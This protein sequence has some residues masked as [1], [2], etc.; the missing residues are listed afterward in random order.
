MTGAEGIPASTR[1]TIASQTPAATGTAAAS[2]IHAGVCTPGPDVKP[3][4][5]TKFAAATE[6]SP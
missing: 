5:C 4:I 1:Q 2:T 3:G 6:R